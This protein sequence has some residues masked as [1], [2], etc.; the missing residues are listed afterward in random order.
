MSSHKRPR[1]PFRKPA[2]RGTQY[3]TWGRRAVRPPETCGRQDWCVMD[4]NHPGPCV[5]GDDDE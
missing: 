3:N 2:Y 1:P 4:K 5:E